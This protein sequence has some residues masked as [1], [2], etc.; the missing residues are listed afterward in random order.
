MKNVDLIVQ[1]NGAILLHRGFSTRYASK[2]SI[3]HSCASWYRG[4]SGHLGMYIHYNAVQHREIMSL[5]H[6]LQCMIRE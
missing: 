3:V 6:T 5:G 2:E 4:E 1:L